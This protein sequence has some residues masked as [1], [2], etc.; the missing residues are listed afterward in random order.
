MF[1]IVMSD[2]NKNSVMKKASKRKKSFIS[3]ALAAVCLISAGCAGAD[4]W[5]YD[6]IT[7]VNDLEG[8]RVGVNLA[9][10]SDYY[11]TG[12]K[13]MELV[14]YDNTSDMIMALKYD[15]IDAI[16]LD[17]DSIKIILSLSEGIDIIEPAFARV[18]SVMYFGKNDKA[19]VEDFNKFL[20]EYKKTDDYQD[21]LKRI[22]EFDGTEYIGSDIPLTGSGKVIRVVAQPEN[23]PRA[24]L[25]PGEKIL[26]GYDTEILKHYANDR[27]YRLEFSYSTYDDGII[28]LQNGAYDVMTGYVSDVFNEEVRFAGLYP[29]DP[30]FEFPMYFIQK[31]R[32]DIKSETSEL[33]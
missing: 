4:D 31:N 13:D 29:S 7:D 11:L 5:V 1:H 18:G 33:D 24:F 26:T 20:A 15:K 21:M 23:F 14:R 6:P 30:L 10:E 8:R 25:N 32:R 22:D 16:A 28:G 17:V 3:A 19:L 12:R 9:W 27:N 2:G